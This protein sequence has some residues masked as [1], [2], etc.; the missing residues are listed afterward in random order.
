MYIPDKD[1]QLIK[2]N[3]IPTEEKFGGLKIL[4]LNDKEVNSNYTNRKYEY[5]HNLNQF[6]EMIGIL[7]V[8]GNTAKDSR[9]RVVFNAILN[10]KDFVQI[11]KYDPSADPIDDFMALGMHQSHARTQSDFKGAKAKN[12]NNYVQY[13]MEGVQELRTI[14]LPPISGWQSEV[15][16][17][18]TIFEAFD[19]S[20]KDFYYGKIYLPKHPIMQSDGQTQTAALFGLA[21][22]KEAVS[23]NALNSI[24]ISLEIELNLNED[25]AGQSFADRNGRGS[26]KNANLVKSMDISA[27][28]SELRNK[29]IKDTVFE[30]RLSDGR[31]GPGN[32]SET[33]V[34]NIV[35]LSTLEQMIL[36]SLTG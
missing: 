13:L 36:I 6:N 19:V 23:K 7:S 14:Y 8:L 28:L 15:S 11:I 29:S 24:T 17:Q 31:S 25:K 10:L 33:S 26:K 27:A 3:Q 16:F 12:K 35:D 5:L 20:N 1:D 18:D 34:I 22:N 32:I 30:G 4:N 9:R 21:G 2:N